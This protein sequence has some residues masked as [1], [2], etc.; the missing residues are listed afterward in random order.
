MT[1]QIQK[2]IPI[3]ENPYIDVNYEYSLT[4]VDYCKLE[5]NVKE[6][7]KEAEKV[8]RRG[9]PSIYE[10]KKTIEMKIRQMLGEVVSL[11]NYS[12]DESI[13]WDVKI[14]NDIKIERVYGA[15]DILEVC[16]RNGVTIEFV[17]YT[18]Y[19]II[20]EYIVA[21]FKIN[22]IKLSRAWWRH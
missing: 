15:I 14:E 4:T 11:V 9:W 3:P 21:Y 20:K 16:F 10:V 18:D 17:V 22:E 13:D 2:Q 8:I 5:E 7:I 1:N 12:F 6:A 19:V